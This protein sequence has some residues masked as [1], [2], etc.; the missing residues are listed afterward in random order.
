MAGQISKTSFENINK[1]VKDANDELYIDFG[2]LLE[3]KKF[4]E[5][6]CSLKLLEE[7]LERRGIILKIKEYK[8]FSEKNFW[9]FFFFHFNYSFHLILLIL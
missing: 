2:Y 3:P 6:F 9:I 4:N 5:C 7:Y 1:I 8:F